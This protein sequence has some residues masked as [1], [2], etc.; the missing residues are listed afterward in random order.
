MTRP[1]QSRDARL[2]KLQRTVEGIRWGMPGYE[3]FSWL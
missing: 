2:E 3:D 1:A